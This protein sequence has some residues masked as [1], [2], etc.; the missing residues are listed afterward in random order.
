M[1]NNIP[2]E[3]TDREPDL[4][5]VAGAALAD[6]IAAGVER[7][8]RIAKINYSSGPNS[9][10]PMIDFVMA[11]SNEFSYEVE[12]N[13]EINQR[14]KY[15]FSES[16][17][18]IMDVTGKQVLPVLLELWKNKEFGNIQA[19]MRTI[20]CGEAILFLEKH[21]PEA[22]KAMELIRLGE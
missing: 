12:P 19:L 15:P 13:P 10:N 21:K 14:F 2:S 1:I 20:G 8:L 17:R 9:K 22:I 4:A 7:F 16:F 11:F 6:G 5:M 18:A 3:Q